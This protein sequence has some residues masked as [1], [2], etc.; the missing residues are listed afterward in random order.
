[1]TAEVESAGAQA[2]MAHPPVPFST[3]ATFVTP[4]RLYLQRRRVY[5]PKF[6]T[7]CNRPDCESRL[8]SEV[9]RYQAGHD[10]RGDEKPDAV[11]C[12]SGHAFPVLD[13]RSGPGGY[14]SY[15]LGPEN[16]DSRFTAHR[17]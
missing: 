14:H 7:T 2:Q 6:T 13:R 4:R 9:G 1:M 11:R 10:P 17:W 15:K 5:T 3:F 12:A 16:T 8:V